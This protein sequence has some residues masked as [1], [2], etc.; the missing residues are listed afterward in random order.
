MAYNYNHVTLVGKLENTPVIS[1][2]GDFNVKNQKATFNLKVDR[3]YRKD[4]GSK[5]TD[6]VPVILWGFLALRSSSLKSN[7]PVLVEGRL[8]ITEN[9]ARIQ[10]ENFQELKARS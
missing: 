5:D 2:E 6:H 1:Q 7:D 9:G 4:D 10:A 3:P 8:E